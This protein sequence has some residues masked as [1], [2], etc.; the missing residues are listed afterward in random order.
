MG[1][2]TA[3]V[4]RHVL[5]GIGV[6]G[7]EEAKHMVHVVYGYTIDEHQVLVGASATHVEPCRAFSAAL[8]TG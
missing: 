4:E 8:H 7:R 2:E 3:L 1:G 6:E 5:D